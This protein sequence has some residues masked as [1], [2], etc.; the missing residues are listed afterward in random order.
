MLSV[1]DLALLEAIHETGSLSRAM[2]SNPAFNGLRSSD[3][4]QSTN[5]S[6]C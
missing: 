4:Q 6:Q 3:R 2:E 1:K 5:F